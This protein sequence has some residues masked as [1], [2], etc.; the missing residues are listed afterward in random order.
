MGCALGANNLAAGATAYIAATVQSAASG[1]NAYATIKICT[2]DG[3]GEDCV[4]RTVNFLY[5]LL[6]ET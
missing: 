2:Q 4:T 3:G 6:V 1:T 5:H